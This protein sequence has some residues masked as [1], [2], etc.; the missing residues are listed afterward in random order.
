[1]KEHR[2]R[3]DPAST[4]DAISP[5]RLEQEDSGFDTSDSSDEKKK[6]LDNSAKIR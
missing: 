5:V 6:Q 4:P 1:M 2:Q 3:G